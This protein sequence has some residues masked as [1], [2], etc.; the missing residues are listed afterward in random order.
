MSGG[1]DEGEWRGGMRGSGEGWGD[2]GE[3]RGVG[4]R[5]RKREDILKSGPVEKSI[6]TKY[7]VCHSHE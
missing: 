7:S 1:G 4:G 3:W 5:G 2:E 6:S